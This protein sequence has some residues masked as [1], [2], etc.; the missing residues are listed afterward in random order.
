LKKT[1]PDHPMVNKGIIPYNVDLRYEMAKQYLRELRE[2]FGSLITTPIRTDAN[3]P[4]AQ[5]VRMTVLEYAEEYRIASRAAEDFR[6]LAEDLLDE[7]ETEEE[8]TVKVRVP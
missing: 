5:S 3:V 1:L 7:D 4:K 2:T 6:T 8:A